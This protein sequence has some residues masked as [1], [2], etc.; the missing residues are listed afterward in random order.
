[1]NEKKFKK[2]FYGLLHLNYLGGVLY[3]LVHFLVTPRRIYTPRRLWAYETWII[4]SFWGIFTSIQLIEQEKGALLKKA[5]QVI[6]SKLILLVFPWGLFL[7]L[8]PPAL[9]N[10]FG[11]NSGYWRALGLASLFGALIY[12]YPYCFWKRALTRPILAFGFLDN[13]LAAA[14]IFFL[15]LLRRIPYIALGSLPLLLFFS[16]FFLDLFRYHRRS[17]KG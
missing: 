13:L 15:F 17:V 2:L 8:A 9:M 12:Y 7:L 14:V 16:V 1:M 3:A 11:L 5:R 4:F 6:L 10:A